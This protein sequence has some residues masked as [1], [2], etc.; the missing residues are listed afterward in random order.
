MIGHTDATYAQTVEAIDAGA[1]VATA[2]L[3]NAAAGLP[4]ASRARSPRLGRTTG[5]PSS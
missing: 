5:L 4:T 2:H 1:T 3:F